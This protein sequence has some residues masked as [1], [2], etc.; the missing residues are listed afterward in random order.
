MGDV[1]QASTSNSK[2]KKEEEQ[3]LINELEEFLQPNKP[4]KKDDTLESKQTNKRKRNNEDNML[5]E[6]IISI[7]LRIIYPLSRCMKKYVI[8]GIDK[9][10]ACKPVVLIVHN[11]KI[12]SLNENAWSSLEKRMQL[13][14]CYFHNKIFGKKTSFSL[15]DSDVEVDVIILRGEQYVRIRDL[16]KHD[17]KVQ[18]TFEEFTMLHSSSLAINNYINQLHTVESC[19]KDYVDTTIDKLPTSQILYS[20]LDTSIMNRLPQEVELY[21]RMKMTSR[22]LEEGRKVQQ[23]TEEEEDNDEGDDSVIEINSQET[24]I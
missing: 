15:L 20:P 3:Q 6:D 16:T 8:V 7:F 17:V 18:L 24:D 11:G 10:N 2:I 4:L 9:I 13:I 19:C 5:L 12:I 23:E 21:R 22:T 14:D 1:E